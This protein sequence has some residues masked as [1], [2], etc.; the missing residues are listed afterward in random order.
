MEPLS[1]LSVAAAVVQFA[2]FGCQLVKSAHELYNS[3][4]S[5]KSECIEF[6][7]VSRELSRLAAS[8]GTKLGD[9]IGRSAEVFVYIWRACASTIDELQGMLSKLKALGSIK[10]SLAADSWKVALRQVTAAG[11]IERLASRLAQI[12]E[13]MN[14]ALLYLLLSVFLPN[15]LREFAKQQAEMIATLDSIDN[16]TKQ[17]STDVMGL[18]D[19][20]PVNNQSETDEMVRYALSHKRRA[21]EYA[22]K[23]LVDRNQDGDKLDKLCQSLY[24]DSMSYREAIFS[25]P[26][27]LRTSGS[28][29]SWLSISFLLAGFFLQSSN[30]NVKLPAP[31]MGQLRAGFR[32]LL[33][34]TG[35]KVKLALLIDGL[36]EIDEDNRRLIHLLR[37]A[38]EAARVKICASSRAW[39]VFKEAYCKNPMLQ[40]QR[41]T[42]EDIK[43][44]VQ[45]QLELSP[46]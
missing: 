29:L 17:F 30:G 8:V 10:V 22:N 44:F 18:I 3:Q 11:D 40:L 26:S 5:Q 12:R 21:R 36:D 14:S 2:D 37:D 45:E 25:E 24:F 39:N 38:N 7:I 6:S 1:A 16:T 28:G 31:T 15:I 34:P 32:N 46:G 43:S 35:E 42:R 27:S 20:W 33:L 13:W 19:K 4:P 23:A 9:N 41:L